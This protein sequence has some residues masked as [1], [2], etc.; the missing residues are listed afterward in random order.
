MYAMQLYIYRKAGN[1]SRIIIDGISDTRLQFEERGLDMWKYKC[2]SIE[3]MLSDINM[4]KRYLHD[5]I[6]DSNPNDNGHMTL[7]IPI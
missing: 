5:C 1:L 3:K 6:L 7:L 4:S 2:I